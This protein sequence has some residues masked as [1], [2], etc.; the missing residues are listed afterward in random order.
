MFR[1]ELCLACCQGPLPWSPHLSLQSRVSLSDS[2]KT[3]LLAS[4]FGTS[5]AASTPPGKE[6]VDWVVEL[7]GLTPQLGLGL[8]MFFCQIQAGVHGGLKQDSRK[9]HPGLVTA[10]VQELLSLSLAL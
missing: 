10:V 6:A 5:P 1:G 4:V 7:E 8:R 3:T 2:T 9:S